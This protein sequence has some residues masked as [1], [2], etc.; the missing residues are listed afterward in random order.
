MA[1]TAAVIQAEIDALRSS[2]AKG[3]LRVRHGDSETTYQD[4]S[5]MRQILADLLAE[6]EGV[7]TNPTKQVRFAT[8]KGL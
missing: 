3:I 4:A 2:L 1:R 6:L 8:R 7:G 5:S